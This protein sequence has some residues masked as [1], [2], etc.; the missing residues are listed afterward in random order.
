MPKNKTKMDIQAELEAAQKRV[1]ELEEAFGSD[2]VEQ[3]FASVFRA[4][5]SQMALTDQTTGRYIEVNEAFLNTLGFSREEVL[6]KT[7][8]ELNLFVDPQ[9]RQDLLLRMR[10]QGFLRNE[11]VLVRAKTGEIRHGIFSAEFINTTEQKLLLT[12]MNDVTEKLQ[13][14]QRWQFALDG[15]DEGVWDW[16]PQ[17]NKVFYS[18]RWKSMLGYEDGE[19]GNTLEEWS[20]RVHRDDLPRVMQEVTRHLSGETPIYKSEHRILR[21]DGTYLWVLDSGKVMEWSEDKKPLRVIGTHKDISERKKAEESLRENEERFSRMF[22]ANPAVQLIVKFDDGI[23]LD[24]NESFCLQTGFDRDELIGRSMRDLNLWQDPFKQKRIMDELRSKGGVHD[25]ELEFWTNTGDLRTLLISFDLVEIRGVLCNLA[26]GVDITSRKQ[27]ERD[28]RF[29]EK[30]YHSLVET[31]DVSI[32]RWL[33]DTTLTYANEKYRKIFNITGNA[34]GKKWID[35]LPEAARASTAI[36]YSEVTKHPR[37]VMYDHPV[38]MNDGKIHHYHWVDTPILGNDGEVL[39]FQSIGIDITDRKLSENALVASEKR[40]KSLVDSQSHYVIRVNMEGRYSYWNAQFEKEFGWL[41]ESEGIQN[42]FVLKAVCSYHH[43]RVTNIVNQCIAEPGKVFTVEIDKPARNGSIRTTLWEFICLTDELDQPYEIQCMGVEITGRK[44]AEDDLRKNEQ[45]LRLF[46]EHSPAAIAM[47][48]LEMRYIIASKRY[49]IDYRLGDVDLVG[50]SHYEIFPEMTEE[51]RHIHQRCLMGEIDKKDED[52]LVRNDGTSDWVRYELRPWHQSNGE[53]GGL[54]FFSEVITE[55]K[56]ADEKL[57]ESERKYRELI[58]GMNDTVWVIDF[59]TRFLDVNDAAV[60]TLGYT[61]EE[62]LSMKVSDIDSGIEPEKIKQL[63]DRLKVE[64]RQVFETSHVTK[65]GRKIPIEVSSSLVSYM[66]EMVV[67]SIA[68]DI[69]DRKQAEEEAR[70]AEQRYR[71]LIENAPDGIVL[72]GIDGHFKYASPSVRR[73]F[74]YSIDETLQSM[75]DQFTHPE[76]LPGVLKELEHLVADP[77]YIPTLQYRFLHKNGEW[78]WIESTFSNLVSVPSVEAIIINF[79]D[80]HE[81]KLAEEALTKSQAL[82]TEAQRIGRIGHMEWNG[83]G[84]VLICSDELYDILEIPYEAQ[85]SKEII[86]NMMKPGEAERIHELDMQA[87]QNHTDMDYEYCIQLKDGRER[88]LHQQGKFSYN[89]DGRPIRMLSIVQDITE[90]K[91]TEEALRAEQARLAGIAD[92]IPGAILTFQLCPDGTFNIP[93]ASKAFEDLYGLARDDVRKNIDSLSARVPH[94]QMEKLLQSV[95]ESAKTLQPWRNEYVYHHP[96][97]GMIWI[98]GFSMPMREADGTIL[99][100]GFASDVTERKT[101]E[102]TLQES[103]LRLEMALK[104]ANAGMWD[105]NVQTGET[106]FNDRWADIVGYSLQEL[107]PISIQTWA[108][109]CH[110]DDL[111]LSDAL[112]QKHFARETEFYECEVRMRHKSGSWVW[113]VDRGKVMEWDAN[114][115]PLRMFGTHLNITERKLSEEE[116]RKRGEDLLLINTLNDAANRGEPLSNI[117]NTLIQDARNMFDCQDLSVY[118]LSPDGKYAELQNLTLSGKRI[119]RIEKLIGRA[120]PRV[121]VPIRED[122]YFRQLLSN[123]QGTLIEDAASI[124]QWIEEFVDTPTLP[125][126]VRPLI[127]KAIPQI[128]KVI[129]INTIFAMPL[130]FSGNVIGLIELSSHTSFD[131]DDLK[132]IRTI[133]RQM[134]AIILRIW[135]VE[136]LRESEEKYRTLYKEMPIGVLLVSVSGEVLEANSATLQILGSPSIEATRQINLLTFAPLIEAGLAADF[137][138][139]V[140]SEQIN[141]VERHYLTKW[142]KS[143]HLYVTFVPV[144]TPQ[145]ELVVQVLIEDITA[146]KDAEN[147]LRASEEKYRSLIKSLNNSISI[148][149]ANGTFLY[150]NDMAGKELGGPPA[151]LIGKTMHDLFPEPFSSM[152]LELV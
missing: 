121:Q 112:L 48:D 114:G 92:T 15:A 67:M 91:Q 76:D 26:T 141:R 152:Q 87:I 97:K 71:S 38:T 52:L 69:T 82:L 63:I 72:V 129:D 56:L 142:G 106:V 59:D 138:K 131:K 4:S 83:S 24:V 16:D 21:K 57:R 143:V 46:I 115:K 19:I 145:Q 17:T 1:A 90:R 78:R 6:G 127:R 100:N 53:V 103:R 60:K 86:S 10:D 134:S 74:G 85:I 120:I 133:S 70:L 94:N 27:A 88:W 79:R 65:N 22:H 31:L 61:R 18:K 139:T 49:L 101:A 84:Q 147:N 122:G 99:W 135:A 2:R 123:E 77:T 107:E 73:L 5:P 124:R 39:E 54:I 104:G 150:L 136:K 36:F 108:D 20:S 81:R 62:L 9:Q 32:C 12:V 146:R 140:D 28:L 110:P 58:N 117:L 80:I 42:A 35:L 33:P 93:Y 47:F 3:R 102:A 45:M 29:R 116:I 44:Q 30:Q 128:Q 125:D 34:E 8:T 7:A 95:N 55:R 137:K 11:H 130:F 75:P 126:I 64:K 13:A 14:E 111:K 119:E 68:R 43:E 113:V 132:R 96:T 50:R 144:I 66:G 40:L 148:V 23:V 51:H 149:D 37:T 98:E 109:L 151:E 41:Y 89:Q 25:V 105:W 118:L